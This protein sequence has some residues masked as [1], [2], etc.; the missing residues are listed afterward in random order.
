HGL[1]LESVEPGRAD[2]PAR[3]YEARELIA[4]EQG[5]LEQRVAGQLEMLGVRQ[6]RDDDLL[7][8]AELPKDRRAVLRM[9][10]ERRVHLIVEVVQER[11]DPP[12]LLVLAELARVEPRRRLDGERVA[13][14]R[15]ALRVLG[16]R[17]PRLFASQIQG[18][19]YHTARLVDH[20]RQ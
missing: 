3:V 5:L 19:G 2:E 7:G 16:E 17:R 9:L 4:G 15:L 18:D 20:R 10:V 13:P 1:R 14:E 8:V 11:R 6:H 12:E